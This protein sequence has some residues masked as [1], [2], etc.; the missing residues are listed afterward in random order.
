MNKRSKYLSDAL[1]SLLVMSLAFALN[2]LIQYIFS[3]QTLIPMIFVFGVFLISFRTES[4]LFGFSASLLSVLLVNFAFSFPYFRFDL[5]TPELLLSA[6]IMLIISFL[7]CMVTK[8]LS[9][10]EKEK[11]ENEKEQLRANLLRAVSHDLR[12][13]LTTIYGSCSAMIE[14]FSSLTE[15]QLLK[16]LSEVKQDSEWLMRMVENLLSIT[17]VGTGNVSINKFDVVLE[18]LI[19]SVILNFNKRY[20]GQKVSVEIPDEFI[21]IG[22]DALLIEQVII[23]LLENAVFHAKGMTKLIL[24][25]RV[26]GKD[27]V[28]EVIDNGCGIPKDKLSSIFGGVLSGAETPADG[29]R[30]NM[31]IGLTVCSAIIAAHGGQVFARNSQNGG[32][33]FGFTLKIAEISDEQ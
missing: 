8:K 16:L 19:D 26:S 32:A 18:E 1:F 29:R 6:V 2:M 13:P 22:M 25:V 4:Y 9:V 7:T 17:K 20:P 14:N 33:V 23:N 10:T 31:G 24:R 12:T 11:A 30:N 28:F 3:I 27:A 5:F 15:P 21:S